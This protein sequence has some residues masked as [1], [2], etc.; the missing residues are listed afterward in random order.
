MHVYYE[1]TKIRVSKN[2]KGLFRIDHLKVAFS[3]SILY[4]YHS[5]LMIE[6]QENMAN[7]I[8]LIWKCF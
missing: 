5:G 3:F 7:V 1:S 8:C 2:K 4:I 6:G